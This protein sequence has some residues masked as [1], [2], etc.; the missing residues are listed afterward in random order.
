MDPQERRHCHRYR[1][2]YPIIVSSPRAIENEK[3]WHYG[4][5]LDAGKD[6]IR[7]RVADFGSLP[8][9]TRLQ[10]VCQPAENERPNN[11]CMPVAIQGI[12]VWEDKRNQE[13]A[14]AYVQ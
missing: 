8:A 5:I 12:V 6:G 11:R 3:G 2:H 4:E 14:L 10:L 13:F 7:M 9:G 1:M